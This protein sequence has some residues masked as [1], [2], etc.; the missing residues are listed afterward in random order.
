MISVEGWKRWGTYLIGVAL[1]VAVLGVGCAPEANPFEVGDR[2][3]MKE[4]TPTPPV[5]AAAQTLASTPTSTKYTY[6]EEEHAAR[7]FVQGKDF[8][9]F[10]EWQD[11]RVALYNNIAG[12]IM[13]YG[14][15]YSVEMVD[16]PPSR[17]QTALPKG[18]VD[19]VMEM[20]STDSPGWYEEY[21]QSGSI[22]AAGLA[23]ETVSDSRIG[24]H[25]SMKEKAP[26]LVEF[27]VLIR[28]NDEVFE[29]LATRITG[30][31]TG[32]TPNVAALIFLKNNEDSW[33][34]WV[35]GEVTEKV[36]AAIK[37]GKAGLKNVKCFAMGGDTGVGSPPCKS[38]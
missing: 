14:Y 8:I 25:P 10:A 17:L 7:L 31:R 4:I 37:A 9:K 24:L 15:D 3:R 12:Y 21:I 23:S 13:V 28:P 33:T 20:A 34:R 1:A 26:E 16:M 35:P 18:E 11:N 27:L 38:Q 29:K 2:A 36:K 22:L 19:I 5:A 32:I 6:T 30:G